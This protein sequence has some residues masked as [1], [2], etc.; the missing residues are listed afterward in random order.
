ML[1][2]AE[3]GRLRECCRGLAPASQD[4]RIDDYVL[5]LLLTVLDRQLDS[6]IVASARRHFE[7]H[8]WDSIRTHDQLA[9]FLSRHP[10]TRAGNTEAALALW[11]YRYWNRIGWLRS[12]VDYFASINVTD[13][14]SLRQWA[15]EPDHE[16]EFEAIPNFGPESFNWLV[17][18]QGVETVK[19]D[20]HVTRF[21]ERC[22]GRR[23]SRD[24]IVAG[25]EQ[26]ARDLGLKAYCLDWRI[27][28]HERGAPGS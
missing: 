6:P 25:L 13:Q 2:D 16:K 17:M 22:V 10:D 26:I 3:L 18:R 14:N 12:L 4:Y 28:E 24:E 20:I 19:V 7:K 27:W 9:G 21:V 15:Y 23:C 5:N 1:T 11:G 8:C